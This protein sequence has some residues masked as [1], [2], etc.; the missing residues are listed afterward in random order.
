MFRAISY[1]YLFDEVGLHRVEMQC[2]VEN[3]KSRA[4]PE[5]LGFKLEGIR[6]GSHWITNRF[7]D[8]AVYGMLSD[9]W[10]NR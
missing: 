5:R 7:V 2:G 3:L 8:H 10:G 9:E 1:T 6:R 4:V